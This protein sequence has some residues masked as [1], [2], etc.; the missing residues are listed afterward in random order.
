MLRALVKLCGTS[1]ML[2]P[3]AIDV[4]IVLSNVEF[5]LGELNLEFGTV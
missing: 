2:L 4:L 3:D 5:G 1:E